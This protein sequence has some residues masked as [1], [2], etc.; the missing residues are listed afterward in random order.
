MIDAESKE[1]LNYS[2]LRDG[3]EKFGR[4]LLAQFK[5]QKGD[6]LMIVS[7]NNLESSTIP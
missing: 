7:P 4:G 6:Q 3:G 5:W 2:T 1:S